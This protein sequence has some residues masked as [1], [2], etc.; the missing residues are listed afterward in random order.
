M[1][2][3]ASEAVHEAE[4]RACNLRISSLQNYLSTCET[5]VTEL[6]AAR[7]STVSQLVQ[8]TTQRDENCHKVATLQNELTVE[9]SGTSV[10]KENLDKA[11]ANYDRAEQDNLKLVEARQADEES[12]RTLINNYAKLKTMQ[13]GCFAEMDSVV[14]AVVS[15]PFKEMY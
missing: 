4:M 3:R 10:L 12:I 6:Q 1:N 14:S 11:L 5:Q 8:V 9:R 15:L 2:F 13:M 7:D